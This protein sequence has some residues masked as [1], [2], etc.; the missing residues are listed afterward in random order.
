[1]IRT[2]ILDGNTV[3]FVNGPGSDVARRFVG[4]MLAGLVSEMS[5]LNDV[6]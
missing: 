2:P 4:V 5:V 3:G 6:S 1:M